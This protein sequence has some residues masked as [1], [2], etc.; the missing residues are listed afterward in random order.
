MERALL[1]Q[2]IPQSSLLFQHLQL[3]SAGRGECGVVTETRAPENSN[4][5]SLLAWMSL[6][7]QGDGGHTPRVKG[8]LGALPQV[9]AKYFVHSHKGSVGRLREKAKDRWSDVERYSNERTR[10]L[11][12]SKSW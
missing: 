7:A 11:Y 9:L 10:I 5:D 6:A 4:S 12:R 3:D 8:R 2:N 1:T